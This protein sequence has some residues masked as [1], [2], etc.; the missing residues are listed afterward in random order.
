MYSKLEVEGEGEQVYSVGTNGVSVFKELFAIILTDSSLKEGDY[1]ANTLRSIFQT[2]YEKSSSIQ[3]SVAN[4][5]SG[6]LNMM[7]ITANYMSF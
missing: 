5:M 7:T 3:G 1:L 4:I 6:T 2:Y